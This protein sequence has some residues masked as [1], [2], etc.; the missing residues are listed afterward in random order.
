MSVRYALQAEL[1]GLTP[2][3]RASGAAQVQAALDNDAVTITEAPN[4]QPD[5]VVHGDTELFIDA[6]FTIRASTDRVFLAAY[7]WAK[8]RATDMPSGRHSY[9]RVR[10]VDDVARTITQRSAESPAWVDSGDVQLPWS[11]LAAP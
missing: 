2:A 10:V 3:Q 7:N 11:T 8:T 9:V 5:K 6:N 4:V 1:G